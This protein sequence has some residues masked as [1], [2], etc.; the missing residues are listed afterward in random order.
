MDRTCTTVMSILR[1]GSDKAEQVHVAFQIPEKPKGGLD[2]IDFQPD[3]FDLPLFPGPGLEAIKAVVMPALGAGAEL[4]RVRVLR[5]GR[6][7]DMF[8]DEIGGPQYNRRPRNEA[9]TAIYRAATLRLRPA[10]DPESLPAIY[11]V[12]VIFDDRIW[13]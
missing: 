2:A 5:N 4:E 10:L 3:D 6:Q 9:A 1:P 12:A 7:A 11:G 8:V 13:F